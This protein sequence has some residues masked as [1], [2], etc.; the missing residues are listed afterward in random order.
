MRTSSSEPTYTRTASRTRG[1]RTSISA[2]PRDSRLPLPGRRRVTRRPPS[3]ATRSRRLR[4]ST[5]TATRMSSSGPSTTATVRLRTGGRM[6]IWG[7][8]RAWR[9]LPSGPRR[10]TKPI[11]TSASRLAPP[12]TSTATATRTSPSEPPTTQPG[13]GSRGEPTSISARPL[14]S[15][16]PRPGRPTA[17]KWSHCSATP[18]G[19][20]GTSTA[21]ATRTSSSEPITTPTT[22]S[23]RDGPTFISARQWAWLPLPPGRPRATWKVPVSAIRSRRPGTSTGTA[24]RTS[25]LGASSTTTARRKRGGPTFTLARPRAWRLLPHG[26]RRATRNLPASAAPSRRPVTST[27]MATRT[28]SSSP[29]SMTTA[30]R[31]RGGPRSITD[32]PP[33]PLRSLRGRPKG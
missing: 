15:R 33:A 13:W 27:A 21:T 20:P 7:P 14:V 17:T 16:P 32:R 1:G 29:L 8:P 24:M 22:R 18:S 9:L 6:S 30:R 12:E 28:S 2:P 4:T 5:A 10:A 26:P 19:R 11:P 31:T 23:P 25:S 3:S